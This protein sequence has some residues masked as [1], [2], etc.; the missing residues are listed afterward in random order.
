[1]SWALKEEDRHE[2]VEGK[3]RGGKGGGDN[4]SS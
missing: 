4:T 2:P 3:N 1:M